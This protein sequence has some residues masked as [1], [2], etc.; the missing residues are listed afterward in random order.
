MNYS[1]EVRQRLVYQ[2]LERGVTESAYGANFEIDL[3]D[4][5][6]REQKLPYRAG[7]TLSVCARYVREE[8]GRSLGIQVWKHVSRW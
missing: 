7:R 3:M 8:E 2:R 5:A 4:S 1:A 6:R